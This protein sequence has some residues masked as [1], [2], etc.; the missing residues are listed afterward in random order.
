M[1]DSTM[2]HQEFVNSLETI[3]RNVDRLITWAEGDKNLGSPSINSKIERI[4]ENIID[5][6]KRSY[7]NA[8]EI[9]EV[10]QEVRAA[11]KNLE[12]IKADIKDIRTA[13]GVIGGGGVTYALIEI[14]RYLI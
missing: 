12:E 8:A 1:K 14:I 7:V 3:S 6:K 10:R 2:S 4:E 5:N 11:E 13:T 9:R